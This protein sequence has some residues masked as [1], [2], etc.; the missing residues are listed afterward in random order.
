MA[1]VPQKVKKFDAY[2][3]EPKESTLMGGVITALVWVATVIYIVIM[4]VQW[5][6]QPPTVTATTEWTIGAGPFPMPWTCI[7]R[8]GCW[9]QNQLSA[10]ATLGVS[11]RVP[12]EQRGACTFVPFNATATALVAFSTSPSEGISVLYDPA[13]AADTLGLGYGVSA[14][15]VARCPGGARDC[16]FVVGAEM[17]PGTSLLNF[18]DT[19]NATARGGAAH[20][21]EWFPLALNEEGGVKARTTPACEAAVAAALTPEEAGRL[22]QCRLRMNSFYNAVTV[23]KDAFWLFIFASAGGAYGVFVQAGALVL[24]AVS[25]LALLRAK[26]AEAKVL[27]QQQQLQR[28]QGQGA[29]HTDEEALPAAGYRSSQHQDG[30]A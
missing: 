12:G 13:T 7:A 10:Q 14:V 1:Q 16:V 2:A 22:V 18:V 9:Y 28:Q 20:R 25:V 29:G 23:E 15:S 4:V 24:T 26:R 3:I 5:R 21:L 17:G 30:R 6:R 27:A 19:T 8:S 11:E